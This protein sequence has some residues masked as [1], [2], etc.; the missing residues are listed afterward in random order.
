MKTILTGIKPTGEIHLGNLFGAIKP[1]IELSKAD[2]N[3]RYIYF[4]ADYHALTS[5][6]DPVKFRHQVYSIASSWLALGLDPKRAIF[7]KQSDVKELFEITWLL[8]CLTP[9]GEMNRAHSYKAKVQENVEKHEKDED[10]GVNMGLYSYPILMASDILAFKTTN[11]PVG[12]DQVQHIEIARAIASRINETYK[13]EILVEPKEILQ[14]GGGAYVPGL[15][16]R[17]MSKSYGNG[18]FLWLDEKKLRKTIMRITTDSKGM[19]EPKDPNNSLVMDLYKLFATQEKIK[20]LEERYLKG[21]GWG[22]AKEE[23]FIEMNAYLAGPREIYNELMANP[24]KIDEI[25]LSG[26]EK[27]RAIAKTTLQE[28]RLA[29]T[30]F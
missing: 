21:I 29:M 23:L 5:E 14:E 17:K 15:D 7:Y 20:N 16:G 1:A 12:R 27:A 28:L 10:H 24:K 19:D 8:S 2:D 22:E 13:K 30:G 11:V 26:A 6:R 9:K 3:N 18:I 4:I 25:L